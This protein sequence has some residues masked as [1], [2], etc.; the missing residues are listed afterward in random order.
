MNF[1]SR[2]F[3]GPQ[4]TTRAKQPKNKKLFLLFVHG[5]GG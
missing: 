1:F 5:A 2:E 3:F 4:R